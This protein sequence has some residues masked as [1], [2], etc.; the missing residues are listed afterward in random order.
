MIKNDI[1]NKI[2]LNAVN[3]WFMQRWSQIMIKES[4]TNEENSD[5]A[6]GKPFIEVSRYDIVHCL[7]STQ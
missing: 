5:N 6:Q 1:K 7:I 3:G 2:L 4:V